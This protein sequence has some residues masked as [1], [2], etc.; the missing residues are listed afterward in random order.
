MTGKIFCGTK[1][2]LEQ[3]LLNYAYVTSNEQKSRIKPFSFEESSID[4]AANCEPRFVIDNVV[5]AHHRQYFIKKS[6][7][8]TE[9]MFVVVPTKRG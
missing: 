6:D 8:E 2:E 5:Y 7:T 3:G 9:R 4:L 1:E